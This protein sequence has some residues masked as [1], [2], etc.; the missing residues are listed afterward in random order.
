MDEYFVKPSAP[1]I[2]II[3]KELTLNE[4]FALP[5]SENK[6]KLIEN[7][8]H[9]ILEIYAQRKNLSYII[10]NSENKY[11]VIK[12]V[13]I[14]KTPTQIVKNI[15][16]IF[17]KTPFI[18]ANFAD[19]LFINI[20]SI[21]PSSEQY[22]YIHAIAPFILDPWNCE[23]KDGVFLCYYKYAGELDKCPLIMEKIISVWLN[24]SSFLIQTN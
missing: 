6:R 7:N 10:I 1:P 13:C 4:I 20:V 12:N 17:G 22:K 21:Q 19:K 16:T 5:Y 2:E 14:N 3:N 8:L 15:K 18:K 23:Y 9:K 24:S 11:N